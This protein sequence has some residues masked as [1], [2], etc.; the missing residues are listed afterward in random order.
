MYAVT[1]TKF[2]N[3]QNERPSVNVDNRQIPKRTP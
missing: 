1:N 3:S 2:I